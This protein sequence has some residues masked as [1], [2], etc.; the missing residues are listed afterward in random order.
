MTGALGAVARVLFEALYPLHEALRS[1]AAFEQLL[2][3]LGHDGTVTEQALAGL[4]AAAALADLIPRGEEL[5]GRLDELDGDDP[6]LGGVIADLVDLGR[7]LLAAVDDLRD[8]DGA[9]LDPSLADPAMWQDLAEALPGHLLVE[10]LEAEVPLVY[11]LLRFCGVITDVDTGGGATLEVFDADQLARVAADPVG[12]VRERYGWGQPSGFQHQELL[13]EIA[14]MLASQGL[15]VRTGPVRDQFAQRFLGG[16]DP[17][18]PVTEL[19]LPLVSG[20][21]AGGY[22]DTGLALVPV[23]PQPGGEISDLLLTNVHI[24]GTATSHDLAPGWTLRLTAGLDA[25]GL[26]GFRLAPAGATLEDEPPGGGATWTVAGDPD[27]PWRPLGGLIELGGADLEVSITDP[28][29]GAELLLTARTR[30]AAFLL[31]PGDGDSFLRYLIGSGPV[32]VALAPTLEWS[33]QAGL[34]VSGTVGLEVVLPLTI[35]L[36]IVLIERLHLLLTGDGTTTRL[37]ADVEATSQIGP[38]VATVQGIGVAVE[39]SPAGDGT[40]SLGPLDLRAAFVPPHGIGFAI[41]SEFAS[42]GGYVESD[43]DAG[44]YAGVLDIELLGVG[45]TAVGIL[46]TRLPDGSD[47]WS[48]FFSLAATFTG[49]PLGFGF[50]LNGVGGL[51]GIHRGLDA[52]ALGDGIRAGSLD[53]ILF[54]ED[55]VADA[56]TII[57]DIGAIFP[58][59]EGQ[60]VFGPVAKI[61]WGTPTVLELDLGVVVEL[62][63]PVTISLLGSLST[64]LPDDDAA[65]LVLNVDV[66]GVLDLTAGTVAVD[67]SL[68]DSQVAGISL[69]GDMAVRAGFLH[70]PSFLL[71]FGGFNPHFDAHGSFPDLD[72]LSVSLDT[73]D[74]LRIGMWGYFAVSSNT[75]QFGAGADLWASAAGLTVEGHL[76][77][78]AL[79]QF[80]PFMFIFQMGFE[81]DVRAGAV[82]L[83]GVHLDLM[84]EG[85]NPFHVVGTASMKILG[86]R[87]SFSVD[88]TIGDRELEGPRETVYATTLLVRAIQD[89]GAWREVPPD[90]GALT[91]VLADDPD[92]DASLQIHPAGGLE[93]V[94]RVVPLQ[95]TLDH[96]GAGQLGDRNRFELREPALGGRPA[97]GVTDVHDWFAPSQYFHVAEEE[98]LSAPSFEEMPAGLRFDAAG[99][100]AGPAAPFVLEYEQIIRDPDLAETDRT[101]QETYTPTAT[102]LATAVRRSTITRA[103]R[104]GPLPA[105]RV[106]GSPYDLRTPS[107]VVRDAHTGA[108]DTT[109]TPT[110]TGARHTWSQARTALLGGGDDGRV[111][112]PAYE[113]A[114]TA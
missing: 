41:V 20:F 102:A 27:E 73:G 5:V 1:P 112:T 13:D 39:L 43:P 81:V 60:Y 101:A 75:V 22:V 33:S 7:D 58:V 114:V 28:A 52:E 55:P 31:G 49:L 25:T 17:T 34:T 9:S 63:D 21:T 51:I 10:Y 107:W 71:S 18:D 78:D 62:P 12:A 8:V 48:L 111:L 66:A 86:V 50:T 113:T 2:R 83:F 72:R 24:G 89:P 97:D 56:A 14:L 106:V 90:A 19:V 95:R 76:S 61:G 69:S 77:F 74:N 103:G 29:G 67:A 64:V 110:A 53:S 109:L 37:Q 68:R 84:V 38:L 92:G 65:V 46:S 30:D 82:E 100:T 32:R 85:P 23:P 108:V 88:E 3:D 94:Q 98:K 26:A 99:V 91:V 35:D 16:T 47:G 42:G 80:N 44:H 36:G 59:Q 6:D 11:G 87:T 96:Y 70:D 4:D 57:G 15:E 40:G 104:S 45:L 93:V 79:I 105:S 54:P